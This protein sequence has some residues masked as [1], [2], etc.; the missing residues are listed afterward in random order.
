MITDNNT[1]PSDAASVHVTDADDARLHVTFTPVS[2]SST[3]E[4]CAALLG[5]AFD[6]TYASTANGSSLSL[7][8]ALPISSSVAPAT[9]SNTASAA[10]NGNTFSGSDSVAIVRN[11]TLT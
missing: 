6:C 11:V 3:G 2:N 9:V 1:G 4:L 8:V 10:T 7:P 5:Q